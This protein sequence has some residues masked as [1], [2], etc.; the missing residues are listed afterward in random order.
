MDGWEVREDLEG[1]GGTESMVRLNCV[2]FQLKVIKIKVGCAKQ[3]EDQR[4]VWKGIRRF[5]SMCGV[6]YI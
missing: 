6:Y 5:L 3:R 1:D 4:L 2:N